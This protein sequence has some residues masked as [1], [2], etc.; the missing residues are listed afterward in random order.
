MHRF[1][2]ISIA[3]IVIALGG[4]IAACD[5]PVD[6]NDDD[7]PGE[8]AAGIILLRNGQELVRVEGGQVPDTLFV[9]LDGSTGDLQV[10]FLDEDGEVFHADDLEEGLELAWEIRGADIITIQSAGAWGFT[11]QGDTA[12]ETTIRILLMHDDHPDF[13]TPDI[14][15]V[16]E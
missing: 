14:M 15:V 6:S 13:T 10:E 2:S 12:G 9:P 7:H 16:V 4:L 1:K 3:V 11:I 5:N 8:E